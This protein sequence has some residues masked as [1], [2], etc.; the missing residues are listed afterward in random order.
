[1]ILISVL[2]T[3]GLFLGL[4]YLPKTVSGVLKGDLGREEPFLLALGFT[5]FT[6]PFL[7]WS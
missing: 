2:Q 5:T 7:C 4:L 1:M 6:A 3:F